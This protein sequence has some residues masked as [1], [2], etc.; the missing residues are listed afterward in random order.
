MSV[1]KLKR[2]REVNPDTVE[3]RVVDGPFSGATFTF[4]RKVSQSTS[5][6][7][8]I[9]STA[10]SFGFRVLGADNALLRIQPMTRTLRISS[11]AEASAEVRDDYAELCELVHNAVSAD[12]SAGYL[13]VAGEFTVTTS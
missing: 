3:F 5:T 6:P 2:F 4:S 11:P 8:V 13:P 12:L 1:I 9:G 7:T 10:A